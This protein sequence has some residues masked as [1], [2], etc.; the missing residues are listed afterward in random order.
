MAHCRAPRWLHAENTAHKC[1]VFS[2][3]QKELMLAAVVSGCQGR[4]LYTVTTDR[5]L[6]LE[7]ISPQRLSISH[8]TD[9]VQAEDLQSLREAKAR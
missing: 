8:I 2:F 6:A 5:I 4:H 7:A 1:V 9:A 3:F